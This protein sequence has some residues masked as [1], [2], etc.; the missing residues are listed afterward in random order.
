MKRWRKYKGKTDYKS[1]PSGYERV[2]SFI[3]ED[4]YE[5]V[6][7]RNQITGEFEDVRVDL[8]VA[9]TFVPNPNHLPYVTHKDGN[10]L[11]NHAD[12]LEWSDEPER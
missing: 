8:L 4:G 9:E 11:N 10:K 6:S 5:V 3:N 2:P 12:N 1:V 7:L